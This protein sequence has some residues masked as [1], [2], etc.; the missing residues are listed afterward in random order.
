MPTFVWMEIASLDPQ[1]CVCSRALT[2][3][4]LQIEYPKPDGK[5]TFDLLSSVALTGTNHEGDQ[6]P[7]IDDVR[8]KR[9]RGAK[10]ICSERGC[11]RLLIAISPICGKKGDP[12]L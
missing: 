5:L 2:P 12:I 3:P 4:S 7:F 10:R 6:G 9:G 11:L 1:I 8:T